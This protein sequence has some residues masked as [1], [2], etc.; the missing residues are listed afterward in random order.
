MTVISR[1]PFLSVLL[2]LLI[3]AQLGGCAD[4]SQSE[5]QKLKPD[6]I[7]AAKINVQLGLAYLE[8]NDMSRAKKTLL[9]AKREAPQEPSVWYGMGYFLERT[10]ELKAAE[11][12]YRVALGLN[13]NAGP[14]LNNYGTFLCRQRRYAEAL[15][16]FEQAVA[17]PN[18]L[19]PAVAYENA[20]L[21][22]LK[23]PDQHLAKHYFQEAKAKDPN[24]SKWDHE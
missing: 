19:E 20:G 13:A 17:D 7:K 11:E 8:K 23:I 16:A 24:V 1:S 3:L 14:A 4:S 2:G 21:C 9:L 6:L 12:H 22:A 15:K 10:G 5:A 18:Y